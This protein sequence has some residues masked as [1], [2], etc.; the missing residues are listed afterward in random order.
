M[1]WRKVNALVDK[2][3]AYQVKEKEAERLAT[4]S[5]EWAEALKAFRTNPTL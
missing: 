1:D 5:P 4:S 3:C 2:L